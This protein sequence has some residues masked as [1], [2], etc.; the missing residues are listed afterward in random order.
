[1]N[2][3][4]T[5]TDHE[6]LSI[7]AIEIS[8]AHGNLRNAMPRQTNAFAAHLISS[9]MDCLERAAKALGSDITTGI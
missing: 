4:P 5:L 8:I 7:V 6:K 1:M 2:R 9:A 3:T